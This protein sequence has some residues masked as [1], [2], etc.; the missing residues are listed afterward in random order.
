MKTVSLGLTAALLLA[1]AGCGRH[2]ESARAEDGDVSIRVGDGSSTAAAG[3]KSRVEINLPG[4]IGGSVNLPASML[5]GTKF[6]IDGVNL[7][8]GAAVNSVNVDAHD[9][10]EGKPSV[11]TFG[12]RAPA[13][14]AAVAD[15]YQQ[16]FEKRT[17]A[18]TR[19]GDT[20]SGTTEDGDSFS[21]AMVPG[22]GGATGT[23]RIIDTN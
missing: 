17:K 15:W 18:V 19:E 6:D 3:D 2:D 21:I 4:G 9:R 10:K 13:D 22:K 7:Y 5:S 14:P 11:V 23:I 8:P 12:F 20:I 1:V 16:Q